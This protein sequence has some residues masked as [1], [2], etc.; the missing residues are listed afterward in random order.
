MPVPFQDSIWS[1]SLK[2]FEIFRVESLVGILD[3]V[4][5]VAVVAVEGKR[6][7][8]ADEGESETA[9]SWFELTKVRGLVE[10]MAVGTCAQTVGGT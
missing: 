6:L 7:V 3:K 10:G 5:A 2:P 8:L 9:R 1:I 4:A